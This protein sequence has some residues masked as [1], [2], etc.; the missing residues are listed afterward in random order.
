MDITRDIDKQTEVIL[1]NANAIEYNNRLKFA[2]V[3]D[4]MDGKAKRRARRAAERKIRKGRNYDRYYR[5]SK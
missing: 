2:K 1:D 5:P 4:A 3:E